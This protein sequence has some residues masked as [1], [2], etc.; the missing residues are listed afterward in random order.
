MCPTFSFFQFVFLI[1]LIGLTSCKVGPDFKLPASPPVKTYTGTSPVKKTIATPYK[2]SAGEAQ[3][4]VLGQPV[5]ED[6]WMLF[7]SCAID[8]MIQTG[9]SNSP[10]LASAKATLH[11][12]EET[13]RAQVGA[14][15]WPNLSGVLNGAR[16]QYAGSSIGLPGLSSDFNL[17]NA[18]VNVSY[19]LDVFG[20][21]RRLIE[22]YRAQV[23]YQRFQ[24]AAAYL[25]LA[26]NIVTTAVSVA[27]YKDQVAVTKELVRV[28][29]E[30]LG[31]M[32]KQFK[33]GGISGAEILTQEKQLAQDQATLPPLELT[34]LQLQHALAVL[35]GHYPSENYVSDINLDQLTLPQKLPVSLPSLLVRQR[36]DVSASEA[37]LHQ[38][39]AEVGVATAN[40]FPQFAI[41]G[42]YGWTNNSTSNLFSYHNIAWNYMGQITQ[43]IFNAGSLEAQRQ[44]AIA[45]FV[46]AE[47]Q[48]EQTV[49]QA[50]KNVADSLRAIEMDAKAFHALVAQENA[51]RGTFVMNEEQL[52]LGGVSYLNVLS[53]KAQYL[54]TKILRIRA[55]AARYNDT[56]ALFVSL[57]GGWWKEK[58]GERINKCSGE[59]KK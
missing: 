29:E 58:A 16:Q 18:G 46:A 51:S 28:E 47:G 42:E 5:S 21:N 24:L 15:L 11:Q 3:D 44:A 34:L 9:F 48:Y 56:V 55:Q 35:L 45:A 12:A 41:T 39:S 26:G 36:P 33:L 20:G 30:T 52:K 4:F 8:K 57:G 1:F 38:A 25:T 10:T 17:Y 19:T 27:S 50:F 54:Q 14:L 53:A 59:I 13:L 43:S 6:W 31:I 2:N 49:L 7:H 22:T 23:D 40:K 37:L 32:K